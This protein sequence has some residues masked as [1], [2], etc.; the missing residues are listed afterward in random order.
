MSTIEQNYA[1]NQNIKSLEIQDKSL[2][3]KIR[4]LAEDN[5]ILRFIEHSREQN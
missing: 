1:E 4:T 3:N 2:S 5:Y